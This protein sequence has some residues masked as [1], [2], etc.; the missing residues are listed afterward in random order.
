MTVPHNSKPYNKHSTGFALL[1]CKIQCLG[2]NSK[3]I[4]GVKERHKIIEKT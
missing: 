2:R 4:E 3:F 1:V